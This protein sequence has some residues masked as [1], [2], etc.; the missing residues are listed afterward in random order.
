[1]NIVEAY[2]QAKACKGKIRG[3]NG[4]DYE[5]HRLSGDVLTD[6]GSQCWLGTGWLDS[7]SF[8]VIEPPKP[9]YSFLEAWKLMEEGKTM[10]FNKSIYR[11]ISNNLVYDYYKSQALAHIDCGMVNSKE[12]ETV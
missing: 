5:I 10:K 4:H 6:A 7:D 3:P 8:E 9:K 12:W 2:R 11:I 1:M